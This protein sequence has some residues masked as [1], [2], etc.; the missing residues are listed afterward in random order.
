MNAAIAIEAPVRRMMPL[1][2]SFVE[3]SDRWLGVI[4][5]TCRPTVRP[6]CATQARNPNGSPPQL[7]RVTASDGSLRGARRR[8]RSRGHA[9]RTAPEAATPGGQ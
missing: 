4:P 9:T 2:N 3:H 6:L 1:L 5:L 8:G 7:R